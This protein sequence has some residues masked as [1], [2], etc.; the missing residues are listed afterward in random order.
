MNFTA[1][2][3]IPLLDK[4]SKKKPSIGRTKNN[5]FTGDETF[6]APLKGYR[7]PSPGWCWRGS[8]CQRR[9][10]FRGEVLH[11]NNRIL[12]RLNE[13]FQS[14]AREKGGSFID[15]SLSGIGN[16]F[17]P[18]R[19]LG[20]FLEEV[21]DFLIGFFVQNYLNTKFFFTTDLIIDRINQIKIVKSIMWYQ[22]WLWIDLCNKIWREKKK[23]F[24]VYNYVSGNDN[25]IQKKNKYFQST[26]AKI[27]TTISFLKDLS[28]L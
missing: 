5:F 15:S 18:Y 9:A 6:L 7:I 26:K 14:A 16:I 17:E 3:P 12:F 28:T 8:S 4:L 1:F 23:D 10:A 21:F 22:L 13:I 24:I 20:L 2:R 11:R 25:K 27:R 19:H